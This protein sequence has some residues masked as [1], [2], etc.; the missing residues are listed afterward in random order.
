MQKYTSFELNAGSET[1]CECEWELR[2]F[3]LKVSGFGTQTFCRFTTFILRHV[4]SERVCS[5][6]GRTFFHLEFRVPD[7]NRLKRLVTMPC[8]TP[9]VRSMLQHAELSLSL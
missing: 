1:Q 9:L 5:R 2:F 7:R 8:A 4:Q 6:R 3:S